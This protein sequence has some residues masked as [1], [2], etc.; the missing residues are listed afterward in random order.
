[1]NIGFG[2]A[3]LLF[4][5]LLAVSAALSGVMRGTVLSIS[6]LSVALGIALAEAGA[7][8]VNANDAAIVHLVELA[9]IITLFSDG[10]SS[11]ASCCERIGDRW[12]GRSLSRCRSPS[13]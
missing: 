8:S 11:S 2:D 3:I 13:G 4:G 10:C 7:V 6:V 1:V 12:R 9:L 5:G